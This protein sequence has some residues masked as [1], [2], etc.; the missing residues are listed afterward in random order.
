MHPGH[1][2]ITIILDLKSNLSLLSGPDVGNLGAFNQRLKTEFGERL[3]RP[4]DQQGDWPRLAQLRGKV[5]IVLSGERAC[6]AAYVQDKGDEPTITVD[7]DGRVLALHQSRSG[8]LWYWTGH[9]DEER[10]VN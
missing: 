3:W 10:S 5:M 7:D 9:I 1:V 2:P 6:R 8:E 4:V